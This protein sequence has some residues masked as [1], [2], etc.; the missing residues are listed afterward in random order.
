MPLPPF[1]KHQPGEDQKYNLQTVQDN[2]ARVL[3]EITRRPQLATELIEKAPGSATT[4]ITLIA[5]QE[6]RIQHGLNRAFRGWRLTDVQA[7]TRIWRDTATK[8]DPKLYLVLR[9]FATVT[10]TVEVF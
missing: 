5:G 1:T 7:D 4:G 6:N 2:T 3:D 9:T 8:E 10:I